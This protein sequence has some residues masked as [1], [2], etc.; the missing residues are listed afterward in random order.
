MTNANI[1]AHVPAEL[2]R[3]YDFKK[4]M[5]GVTD[6]YLEFSKLHDGPDI[7][8]TPDQGGHW[9][10]TR[11]EDME[12]AFKNAAEF[13]SESAL[14]PKGARPL[15]LLPL[16]SDAPLLQ[17][18]RAILQPFFMPDRIG[19]LEGKIRELTTSLIDDVYAKGECEFVSDF[20]LKLPIGIFMRLVD[21]PDSDAA[22]LIPIADNFFHGETPEIQHAATEQMVGYVATKLQERKNNLGDDLLSA[23]LTGK[24]EGGTRNLTEHEVLGM[25]IV[26]LLGGLDTVTSTLG[27]IARFLAMND[28][29]RRQLVEHPELINNAL[30]EIMRRHNIGSLAR[31]VKQDM[32][33]KG[34]TMKAG[35]MVLLPTVAAGI[36]ERRFPDPFKVDFARKDKKHLGF[37]AGPH[38]CIGSWLGRTELRSFM[39]EWLKRIPEFSMKPGAAPSYITGVTHA[40]RTLHLEWKP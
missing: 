4:E 16:E 20:A 2:V 23:L 15:R 14:I 7:F 40:L 12:Y 22:A 30:E 19:L 10:L 13:S 34:I 8:Y 36:D 37:G 9:V 11:F 25:G 21:C 6:S 29:H 38:S 5:V 18:Y 33:Y 3:E 28:S 35:E 24:A 39:T 17:D 31:M 27:W 26:L 1:P 32:V